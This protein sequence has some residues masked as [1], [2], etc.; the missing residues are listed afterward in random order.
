MTYSIRS[1]AVVGGGYMGGGIAATIAGAGIPCAL[2]DVDARTAQ[3]RVTELQDETE[4]MGLDEET[5]AAVRANLTAAADVQAAVA[6]RDLV[7]E[8]V[9][10]VLEL[11]ARTLG[12]I[13]AAAGP[14]A[15]VASNTS[16]LP[17][18]EL[19]AYV[20]APERFLGC[21]WM[22]PSRIVPGVEIIPAAATAEAV[23]AAAT[24]FHTAIGKRP[25]RVGDVPGFVANRLQHA[26][27][28]EALRL[29]EE[30]VASPEVVDEV[31]RTSFGYRLAAFGPFE[32]ADMAGLDVYRACLTTEQEA[33]GE[34]FA[35]SP[36]LDEAATAGR[37]GLK[38][39]A[40]L[41][42]LAEHDPAEVARIRNAY[43]HGLT[44]LLR[45][46]D[47]LEGLR[48]RPAEEAPAAGGDER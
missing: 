23:V 16:T 12:A 6:D 4:A 41:T 3:R 33:Y 25:T 5:V 8:A 34:R 40:G 9:P 15:I 37:L 22:N 1:A 39:G 27:F 19:S 31:T 38:S 30:G 36:L 32:V 10:E 35:S 28:A 11:K 17:I 14:E 43:F 7:I 21:H 45:S 26:L 2:A 44:E 48:R 20:S 24:A 46:L 47:G 42:P 29:V 13:S 18:A